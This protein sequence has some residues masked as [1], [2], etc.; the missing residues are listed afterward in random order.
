MTMLQMAIAT[1]ESY[2][3]ISMPIPLCELAA[4]QH[5][6]MQEYDAA[7]AKRAAAAKQLSD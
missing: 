4:E 6:H 2:P 5:A 3:F 7:A 1:V